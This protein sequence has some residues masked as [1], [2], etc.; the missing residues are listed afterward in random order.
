[1]PSLL[2]S[3]KASIIL[4]IEKLS[5][6]I[7][8]LSKDI[9][10]LLETHWQ[11][12]YALLQTV[13]GIG[14]KVA[15]AL[16]SHLPELGQL[17]RKKIGALVGVVPY[18]KSSGKYRGQAHS[19]GGRKPVRNALY[20]ATLSA[21]RYNPDIKA[22]FEKLVVAGKAKKVAIVACMHRL[23][24]V[25]NGMLRTNTAYCPPH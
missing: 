7:D 19:Q 20:M 12:Q 16:I 3:I 1:M 22:Y 8:R 4:I 23:L 2:P 18:A 13:K 11:A 21:K 6:E 17:D 15:E 24:R 9:D 25:L 14:T 10:A 5:Q